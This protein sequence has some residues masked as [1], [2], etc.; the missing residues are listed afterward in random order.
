VS[1]T[2]VLAIDPGLHKCGVAVVDAERGLLE[3]AVLPRLQLPILLQDWCARHH[4]TLIL[5][6][7][8]TGSRDLAAQLD[9]LP[10]AVRRVPERDTTRR[11]RE[12][13]FAEHPPRG[14]RRLLPVSL[15]TP[16]VPIDDYAAWVL[17]EQFLS[18]PS[19]D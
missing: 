17:A 10:V 4:P 7:S 8:G 15:Q 18:V 14:W 6:G 12:R 16:P 3:R 5:L 1:P 11:A 2:R 9:D 19:L 13:Y